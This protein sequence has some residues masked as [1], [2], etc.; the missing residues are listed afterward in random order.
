MGRILLLVGLLIC[1][2]L[3]GFIIWIILM[4]FCGCRED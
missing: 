2:G 3:F 4:L 1:F